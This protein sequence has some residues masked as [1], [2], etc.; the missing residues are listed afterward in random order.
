MFTLCNFGYLTVGFSLSL[1][2]KYWRLL[3]FS[4]NTQLL[5]HAESGVLKLHWSSLLS[6]ISLSS[7]HLHALSCTM[8]VRV[9]KQQVLR[10]KHPKNLCFPWNT[11]MILWSSRYAPSAL[12]IYLTFITNSIW[13]QPK[14]TNLLAF[15]AMLWMTWIRFC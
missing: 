14:D 11:N 4:R 3:L 12:Y 6:R 7:I 10:E 2:C 9:E 13:S 8:H 5:S 1:A 15:V